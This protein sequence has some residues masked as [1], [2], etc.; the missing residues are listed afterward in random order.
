MHHDWR[1]AMNSVSLS[2]SRSLRF[3]R[4]IFA[5]FRAR[6]AISLE[7]IKLLDDSDLRFTWARLADNFLW[8]N[9][10]FAWAG[11]RRRLLS[12]SNVS[13]PSRA[14]NADNEGFSRCCTHARWRNR[15]SIDPWIRWYRWIRNC[16]EI[17]RVK[18][19]NMKLWQNYEVQVR[20]YGQIVYVEFENKDSSLFGDVLIDTWTTL[21]GKISLYWGDGEGMSLPLSFSSV[22]SLA[23]SPR[24]M[25]NYRHAMHFHE[26]FSFPSTAIQTRTERRTISHVHRR[27]SHAATASFSS[28]QL[29]Q[30]VI[31]FL[32]TLTDFLNV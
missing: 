20:N 14:R 28:H 12:R 25:R 31:M 29:L 26:T 11:E 9:Y 32:W 6:L 16:G 3:H 1:A 7:R 15:G 30:H 5:R 18:F 10:G 2:A 13:R 21:N 8:H 24:Q 19:H 4:E 22:S 17:T 27:R 23:A